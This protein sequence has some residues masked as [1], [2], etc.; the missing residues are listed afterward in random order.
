MI[1]LRRFLGIISIIG[2]LP[3]YLA[4]LDSGYKVDKAEF[5]AYYVL[6]AVWILFSVVNK[7]SMMAD[8][9]RFWVNLIALGFAAATLL[10][11]PFLNP[12]ITLPN[13]PIDWIVII[14]VAVYIAVDIWD[15]R[16]QGVK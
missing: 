8:Q 1:T 11:T 15:I 9:K 13:G 4:I 16:L 7:F 6:T 3:V 14:F 12:H 2:I 5:S 10:S